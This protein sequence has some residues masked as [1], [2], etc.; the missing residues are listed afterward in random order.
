MSVC[1][2]S[3]FWA[4]RPSCVTNSTNA[5]NRSNAEIKAKMGKRS[6]LCEEP[7]SMTD[8]TSRFTYSNYRCPFCDRKLDHACVEVSHWRQLYRVN[9]VIRQEFTAEPNF[10]ILRQRTQI[11]NIEMCAQ[12]R[13]S[14]N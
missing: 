1:N 12:K 10:S 2:R 11:R 5:P 7:S 8:I 13:G 6:R 3:R 14:R 9:P 4:N